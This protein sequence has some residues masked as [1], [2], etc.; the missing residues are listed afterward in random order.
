[1]PLFACFRRARRLRFDF[2]RCAMVLFRRATLAALRLFARAE[3]RCFSLVT[4]GIV[5]RRAPPE[6]T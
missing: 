6:A 1:M 4:A 2:E 3:R 5:S